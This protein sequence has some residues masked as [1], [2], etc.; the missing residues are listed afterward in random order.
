MRYSRL[1]GLLLIPY[2]LVL[3]QQPTSSRALSLD[4]AIRVAHE[5]NPVF[6]TTENNLRTSEAQVHQA[7]ATLLPSVSS[8]FG[9]RYQQAGTQF[10]QGLAL[11]GG[12]NGDTYQSS[13]SLGLG[14]SINGSALFAPRAARASRSAAEADVT[15]GAEQ[16]RAQVTQQYIAALESQAQA[17]LT[18]TLVQVSQGQLD[19]ANAK[20]AVGAGTILDVRT[21]EVAVGQSRID[22]LKAHNQATIDKLTL[23]QL[24]GVPADT[25]AQLTTTFS[26]TAP[27][28]SLDSLLSLAHHVNPDLSARHAREFAA[29]MQ[30]KSAKTA[31]LPSLSVSTGWGGNSQ[32]Y[33]SPD[34]FVNQQLS[35]LETGYGNCLSQDSLRV[36][37]GL[38]PKNKCTAPD[39]SPEAVAA[40]RSEAS[41]F[42]FHFNRSPFGIS[43]GLSLPIFNNYQRESQLEQAKVQRDNAQFDL[44]ARNLQLTTDVT[45]AYLNLVTA[46]KTVDLQ[47]QNAQKAT[48]ELAFAQ[49]SYKVGSKTFLD[50]TTARGQ[51]EQ[52][53]VARV[54]SIY[55][56]HKAFAALENAVGRPLR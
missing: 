27:P 16:L 1:F 46:Q 52:A 33:A 25:A 45:Q 14:Y 15:S 35:A 42:P 24:M 32:S 56:Y 48:E 5:N 4:D 6:R 41:Q 10:I 7:Y 43:A 2:S 26:I 22:A 50:V 12:G 23:F 44:R 55:D 37:A 19:L 8:S 9:M 18:D 47:T 29:E 11:G 40:L 49:E 17:A 21:A 51:Y 20:L 38:A 28:A 36:G 30:V 54:N 53:Q 39:R 34:F 3:A 13:Y 31:Y